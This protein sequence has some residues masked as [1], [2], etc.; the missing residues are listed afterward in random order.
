MNPSI[1]GE[2]GSASDIALLRKHLEQLVVVSDR[3]FSR[4]IQFEGTSDFAFMALNFTAKQTEHARSV[5]ILGDQLDVVLV[6]RSMFEGLSQ[7]LWASLAPKERPLR[8]RS[9]AYV[10]D[11]R[12]MREQ[13]AAGLRVAADRQ[14]YIAK[15]VAEYGDS[16][17][18]PKAKQARRDGKPLPP[19][20][21]MNKWY[22][23]SE[24][25]VFMAVG[26]QLA[27]EALYGPFSE[28]HHWRIGGFGALMKFDEQAQRFQM[29]PRD[30]SF[31]ASALSSAFQCLWQTLEVLANAVPGAVGVDLVSI[32]QDFIKD[33]SLASGSVPK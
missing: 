27:Y 10:R 9:F 19:D 16:F 21:Y 13:E 20:P 28:W 32:R 17:L 11:W 22:G 2:P 8:W 24:K 4:P 23:E 1:G 25:N 18:T 7:L 12:T 33:C 30:A 31:T 14:A 15:G 5:L 6:A 26:G 29:T 3:L